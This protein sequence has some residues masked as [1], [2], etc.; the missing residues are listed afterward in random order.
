MKRHCE[1]VVHVKLRKAMENTHS[2][3]KFGFTKASDPIRE[4]VSHI[5]P[6]EILLILKFFKCVLI[7]VSLLHSTLALLPDH[8]LNTYRPECFYEPV[9]IMYSSNQA[10][11]E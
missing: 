10:H 4:Q 5:S 1:G 2:L 6:D 7:S 3:D 8:L 9:S 11:R